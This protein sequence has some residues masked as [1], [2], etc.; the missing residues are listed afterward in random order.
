MNDSI[1]NELLYYNYNTNNKC[2]LC[3]TTQG[4]FV[5]NIN[6]YNINTNTQIS[7]GV[8]IIDIYKMT[9]IF[10]FVGSGHSKHFPKNNLII[11][12]D[13]NKQVIKKIVFQSNIKKIASTENFLI[14]ADDGYIWVYDLSNNLINFKKLFNVTYNMNN[15]SIFSNN[16]NNSYELTLVYAINEKNLN[17]I[18]NNRNQTITPHKNKINTFT[19]SYDGNYIATTSNKNTLIRIYNINNTL[20]KE[21]R[22]NGNY[23]IS[24]SINYLNFSSDSTMIGS[25]NDDG[26]IQLFYTNLKSNSGK[27]TKINIPLLSYIIPQEWEYSNYDIN[28]QCKFIFDDDY[29]L[30]INDT[31]KFYKLKLEKSKCKLENMKTYLY[32]EYD[33][34]FQT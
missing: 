15:K 18:R 7:G 6:D 17:V 21:F 13:Q 30:V 25:V 19:C 11:W 26:L 1:K 9:N 12:D 23:L 20:L 14:I 28:S 4:F 29:I 16:C 32:S 27:N 33:K 22:L 24:S 5:Y 31:G 2:L 10:F 3:G 34:I 8:T